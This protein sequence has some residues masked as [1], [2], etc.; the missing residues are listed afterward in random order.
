MT[1]NDD[2]DR[3][4]VIDD[5]FLPFGAK[6]AGLANDAKRPSLG[7]PFTAPAIPE[8]DTDDLAARRKATRETVFFW[9]ESKLAFAL[10]ILITL[11]SLLGI[12]VAIAD[13]GAAE[14]AGNPRFF[15]VFDLIAAIV[16]SGLS[17][18]G[19]WMIVASPRLYGKWLSMGYRLLRYVVVLMAIQYGL[20]AVV[21]AFGG[22]VALLTN[23]LIAVVLVGILGGIF[24]V[25][26]KFI[27]QLFCFLR[28][29]EDAVELRGYGKIPDSASLHV[30]LFVFGAL[31]TAGILLVPFLQGAG[32]GSVPATQ[33]WT[34]LLAGA[35]HAA[36]YLVGGSLVYRYCDDISFLRRR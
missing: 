4:N 25:A 18:A 21:V 24:Y 33:F 12:Y 34:T 6:P 19:I 9:A 16:V 8:G 2:N 20:A 3:P 14:A 36:S 13:I 5:D 27:S 10:A 35:A 22:L 17:T 26:F 31:A 11:G 29:L 28:Q 32:P 7:S 30:F 15:A 23:F 1:Y